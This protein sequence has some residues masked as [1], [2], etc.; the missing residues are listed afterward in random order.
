MEISI[1]VEGQEELTWPKWKRLINEIEN[2]G[3]A[4]LFRSD[5]FPIGKPALELIVSLTYLADHTKHI[6]FGSLVAPFSFRN[7]VMLARQA[8]AIDDLSNGRLVL[9]LGAGW[10]PQEHQVWG[11]QLGDKTTRSARFN[12]GLEVIYQLFHSSEP[13]SYEGQ[14]YQLH[15]ASLLPRPMRVGG[16]PILIGGNGI[17]RTLPLVARYANVW[18][19]FH[20]TPD[21]FRKRSDILDKLLLQANRET[22]SVKR[23][24]MVMVFCGRNETELKRRAN[25]AYQN[26]VPELRDQPFEKL[27][28]A[29]ADMFTP[30]LTSVG[31]SFCPLV[32]TPESVIEQVNAYADAGVEEL[33]IQWWDVDD[34]EGLEMYSEHILSRL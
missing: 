21:T 24:L 9:G 26:W 15:E 8:A 12:E 32:G 1:S 33:M 17:Q 19:V 23:T 3:Y 20:L 16:P 34:I 11:Y 5:H 14:Y 28:E 27:T 4:G 13:I 2:L 31:A 29:L 25:F 30:L 22:I 10:D 18:N 7:P 6:H